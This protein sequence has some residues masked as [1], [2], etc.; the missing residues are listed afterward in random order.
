MFKIKNVLISVSDKSNLELLSPF[1]EKHKV[2]IY[3]SGGTAKYLN[4]INSNL[5]VTEISKFTDF[6]EILDGRVKT[7]HPM[8][9]GG[10]L[11]KR[12][13]KKHIADCKKNNISFFDLVIVNLYPFE[14]S[15]ANNESVE[16]CIENIDIG[17]PTLIRS[18]AKNF[19]DV[20][21]IV[22]KLSLI[23]I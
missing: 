20:L 15:I 18:A 17:G 7:L 21:V 9:H 4:K 14:Q 1:F 11:A 8:I 19:E 10:I 13:N 22:S 16:S 2:K 23:H 12:S 6:P 5:D 3:S